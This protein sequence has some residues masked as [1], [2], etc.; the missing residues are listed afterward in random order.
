MNM[1][2]NKMDNT[3]T[4]I[5]S[6]IMIALGFTNGLIVSDLVNAIYINK[7][8]GALDR[9]ADTM[10]EKDQ[11]IDELKKKLEQEKDLNLNL[12][13]KLSDEKQRNTD[14]LASVQNVVE[15]YDECLPRVI[16]APRGPLKRSRACMESDSEPE[17]EQ[18]ISP[19]P[20]S[21]NKD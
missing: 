12:I 1:K 10:F 21:Y 20:V 9:A 19:E 8:Q 13:Q 18:P 15:V 14:I 7:L 11:Q 6:A 3:M 5:I 2:I 16:E 17:F 4:A